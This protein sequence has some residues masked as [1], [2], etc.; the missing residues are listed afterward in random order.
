MCAYFNLLRT[1][2]GLF[3]ILTI[4]SVGI[5]GIYGHNDGLKGFRNYERS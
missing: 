4:I 1:F 2:I 5:I 3:A